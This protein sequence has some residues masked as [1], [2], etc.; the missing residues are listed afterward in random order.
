MPGAIQIR[1]A[2]AE[3]DRGGR[4]GALP[5]RLSNFVA[6]Y[7]DGG[8]AATTPAAEQIRVSHE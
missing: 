5:N 8:F 1:E 3:D 2:G 6:L 4:A 7:T